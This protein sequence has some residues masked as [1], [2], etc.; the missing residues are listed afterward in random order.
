MMT[1]ETPLHCAAVS[2]DEATIMI[3]LYYGA[4]RAAKDHAGHI[5]ADNAPT[6]EMKALLWP[7]QA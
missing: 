7:M 5:P 3:L 1:M 6:A 2:G 4:E